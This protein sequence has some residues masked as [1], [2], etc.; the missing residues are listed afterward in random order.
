MGSPVTGNSSAGLQE[1]LQ[2]ATRDDVAVVILS[3][4]IDSTIEHE[5]TDRTSIGVPDGQ[6]QLAQ[7]VT[8]AV[9]SS[10][11]VVAVLTNGGPLSCTWVRDNIPTLVEA[12]EGGQFGGTALASVLMGDV[13]PSGVLPFSVFPEVACSISL[14]Y[15]EF[16]LT[17]A[18]GC[19]AMLMLSV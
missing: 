2:L 15:V 11:P 1:A 17:H 13:N 12:F 5:G 3:I 6:I 14:S 16:Q 7:A 18:C 10:K 9:G 19:R 4:G 8:Q